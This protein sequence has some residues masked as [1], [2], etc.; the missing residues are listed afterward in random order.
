MWPH[1]RLVL[2]A[3]IKV[4]CCLIGEK[5]NS[6]WDD[7]Y[8]CTAVVVAILLEMTIIFVYVGTYFIAITAIII[9]ANGI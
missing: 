5:K 2:A 1:L 8:S 4:V 9:I 3:E 6:F 7:N